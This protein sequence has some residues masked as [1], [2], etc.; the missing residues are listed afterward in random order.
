VADV[1]T[2]E[3]RS[4]CMAQVKG[5]NTRLE[6]DFRKKLWGR[7][8]RYRVGYKL[9]GKPDLVFIGPKV[10]VFIDGCFWHGCPV[11][12]Q[13]PKTNVAF[14]CA[15]LSKNKK[16]DELVNDE[17]SQRGWRVVRFWEHEVKRDFDQCVARLKNEIEKGKS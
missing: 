15:K 5:K 3:Q 12:G 14:W 9:L 11:H 7:G 10:A 1:L 16:R 8:F 13:Q 4:R 6:V 2:Q 17:L